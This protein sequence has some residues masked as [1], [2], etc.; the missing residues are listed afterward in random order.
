[1]Y[2]SNYCLQKPLQQNLLVFDFLR[3]T[4]ILLSAGNEV[5]AFNPY[6][7]PRLSDFPELRHRCPLGS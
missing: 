2:K 6:T 7:N 1:V 3:S 4:V 5:L